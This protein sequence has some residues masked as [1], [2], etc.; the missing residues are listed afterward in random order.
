MKLEISNQ[1][2]SVKW[3]DNPTVEALR[4]LV[5]QRTIEFQVQDYAAM[6]KVGYL[7]Q[8]L[9]SSNQHL[10]TDVGDITLYQGK[11]LAFY[12]GQ[13]SYSLTPIGKIQGMSKEK[14]RQLLTSQD[15]LTVR[16]S[17]GE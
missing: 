6:E 12:Y 14:I 16:I 2:I 9:P 10:N 13:N 15:Q 1:V 17:M 8:S 7:P 3:A 5:D 4:K 11:G